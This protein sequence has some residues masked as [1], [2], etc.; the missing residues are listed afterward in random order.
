MGGMDF[1]GIDGLCAFRSFL[2]HLLLR[3]I[4]RALHRF[5][6]VYRGIFISREIRR[7]GIRMYRNS[8]ALRPG[9]YRSGGSETSLPL[10]GYRFLQLRWNPL[11]QI[12]GDRAPS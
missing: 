3:K 11:F 10:D 2:F 1:F 6:R 9:D 5:L 4:Q 8:V 7:M 12:Y